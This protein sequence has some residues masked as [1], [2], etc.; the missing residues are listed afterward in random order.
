MDRSYLKSSRRERQYRFFALVVIFFFFHFGVKCCFSPSCLS[1][2]SH[3]PLFS[4]QHRRQWGFFFSVGG[5]KGDPALL[6]DS[7]FLC[8]Y[9]PTDLTELDSHSDL[10]STP[11]KR[12]RRC[13]FGPQLIKKK[14]LQGRLSDYFLKIAARP[15]LFVFN[16]YN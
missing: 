6:V 16:I 12:N 8:Y 7:L 5:K 4:S 10:C 1:W 15:I 11:Q 9:T 14:C 3:I 13:I 2:A